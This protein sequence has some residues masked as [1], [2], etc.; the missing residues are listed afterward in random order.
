MKKILFLLCCSLFFSIRTFAGNITSNGTGGGNWN[1]T[2]TWV[3][4]VV[5]VAGDNA[6]I[7]VGDVITITTNT[8]VTNITFTGGNGSATLQLNA[9]V[10]LTASGAVTINPP[11]GGNNTNLLSIGDGVLSC[12]SLTTSN[13]G[14]NTRICQ[15]SINTGTLTCTG[16][17]TLGN[18]T[19]R[20]TLTFTS[21]GLLQLGS[22]TNAL[23]NAQFTPSTGTVEYNMAGAQ[24]VLALSYSSL[25]CSGSGIKSLA[26]ATT[27]TGNLTITGTAQL[28]V[29]SGSNFALNVAGNWNVTSTNA[30]PFNAE[31]G[32]VTLNGAALQNVTTVLAGGEVFYNLTV[33]NTSGLNP[34]IQIN[35][36][37]TILGS[38]TLNFIQTTTLTITGNLTMNSTSTIGG[39][40]TGVLNVNGTFSDVAGGSETIGRVTMNV[41][42]ASSLGGTL[43][44]SSATGT[45]NMN[46]GLT[47]ANSSNITYGAAATLNIGTSLTCN[48]TNS[49]TYSTAGTFS[50]AAVTI[51][52][53]TTFDGAATGITNFASTLGVAAAANLNLGRTTAT[54]TG[55][56]T[57]TGSLTITNVTGA[58]NLT[59]GAIIANGGNI[60]FSV[61]AT[62]TIGTSLTC[63][64]TNSITYNAA[65][66][67]SSTAATVNGTTIIDGTTTG[68]T[69]FTSTVNVPSGGILTIGNT[70]LTISN[71]L[72]VGGTTAF[73]NASG[74]KTFNNI[75]INAGGTWNA[76]AV[77]QTYYISAGNLTNN[78]TFNAGL[79]SATVYS[80]SGASQIN[81]T[82]TI[83]TVA[84]TA[85]TTTNYATLTISNQLSGA[86]SFTQ[87][88]TGY[89][90]LS[91]NTANFTVTTFVA[92]AASNTV[93]YTMA[94]AQTIKKVTYYNLTISTS[95]TKTLAGA[96]V[97][98]NNV[99]ITGTAQLDVSAS[100][101][102]LSVG[103]NWNLTSTNA[104]PFN[105][106]A[107]TVTFNGTSGTQ[108]LSTTVSQE[109]FYNL[110]I[111]NISGSATGVSLDKNMTVNNI[112][113]LTSG[114]LNIGT[115]SLTC[116]G[117]TAVNAGG[118]SG[119]GIIICTGAQVIFGTTLG[120][121]TIVPTVSI[122]TSSITMQRG[123][124]SNP[125]SVYKISSSSV[126]DS[127]RGGNTFNGTFTLNN[128]AVGDTL[129]P[130][131]DVYLGANSGDPTDIFNANSYFYVTGSS[132][133]RC[134][135]SGTIVFNAPAHFYSQ[136]FASATKTSYDRIQPARYSPAI[137]TFNDSSIFFCNSI[138]T[139]IYIAYDPG[140]TA[141]F[142]KPVVAT[143]SGTS[144]ANFYFGGAGVVNLNDDVYFNNTGSG[145]IN[146]INQTGGVA[147]LA[148]TKRL[149]VGSKGFSSGTLTMWNL[150]Q[151]G[152]TA[153]S[154]T[155]TGSA[156]MNVGGAGTPCTFNASVAFTSPNINLTENTFNGT[157]NI[158]TMSGSTN[159]N[160]Y[161]GNIYA[162]GST[163]TFIN[164]S[165]GYW[166]LANTRGDTCYGDAI[167]KK[168]STG[169]LS[170][171]YNNTNYFYGNISI[172]AGSDSI[173][174][175]AGTGIV[176][177]MGTSSSAFTN[178][179]NKGVSMKR[180]VLNKTG[181]AGFTLNNNLGVPS[182][183]SLTLTSGLL[184]TSSTGYLF[185]MN[186]N[187]T[188]PAL[189]DALTSYI[190]GPMRYD[191]ASNNTTQT[192]NF[193]IG[194]AG[195][196]RPVVLTVR[197]NAAT[198]YSYMGEVFNA[199]PWVAMNSG[200]PYIAT[201]MPST[202]DTISG[203]HY[204]TFN[205]TVTSSGASASATNLSYSAGAYPLIQLYFGPNDQVYQGSNLTIVK[206]TSATP[207][208]WIDIGGSCA[209][210]NF[211]S[212]QSGNVTST[213]SPTAFNSFSSFTLGSRNT[214]W[215]PLPI[216]LLDFTA[217]PNGEKVDIKWE[218][219][220]EEN[221]SYFTVEKSKDGQ[222]F[223]KLIDV[224]GAGN[225]HTVLN[226]FET[227]YQ[228]YKGTSYYRLKQ[229]DK[230]GNYKYFNVVS[231]NFDGQ[232]NIIICP[233]P[234]ISGNNTSVKVTGYQN[235]EVLMILTDMQGR[236]FL[237]KVLLSGDYEH[238]FIIDETGTLPPGTYIVTATSNN[239][240]YNYKLIVR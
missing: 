31:A 23:L 21:G 187:V 198:S 237:T 126:T 74:N 38:T 217:A 9:G 165:T 44:L 113:T 179:G 116:L 215:N 30:L 53:T 207:A 26:A 214:G 49:V 141:I 29:V 71:T 3:G 227:D 14:T 13:S 150:T 97:V 96:T 58:K 12:A 47:M 135:Q 161:G 206:N 173:D 64:G 170:A 123:T 28:D 174:F 209:L 65:G 83:P 164:S 56:S 168:A 10:V 119:T 176:T 54:A 72:T 98:S 43:T 115:Y 144:Q 51:N 112:F 197:H 146:I 121:P 87:G 201:N 91:L 231:V 220:S 234:I 5:P 125:V 50:T 93:D 24:P 222:S 181:G 158:F 42:G 132:R 183:G 211:S 122:T 221:N 6:I 186:Q 169:E 86:G 188:A 22:N 39:T 108:A 136:G 210:G 68:T 235:E 79:T 156:I 48:G 82:L 177:L 184:N 171:A 185:L 33:S 172:A 78:G 101:Y 15:I 193:P 61:A 157:T 189:T 232:Q 129:D 228:P 223:T 238:P 230:N 120:G 239:K 1:A 4:G 84:V 102:A 152:T 117:N 196:C 154:L 35:Q 143:H 130:A 20:N 70:A 99:N 55:V 69:N 94:G 236:E 145:T 233:N 180:I 37:Q 203:V 205:R 63:N 103:G 81:G 75:T 131:G 52:G 216:Q 32:T 149:L 76:S 155:F 138:T 2:T 199:N 224:P 45:K 195:D 148:N 111:N 25:K 7:A 182:G 175:G 134:P 202:V 88:N 90:Y 107:G 19:T 57:I 200:S 89:L 147:T 142:N 166:R 194:K 85:N 8:A 229:T 137:V 104:L 17:F 95:G 162:S 240:I 160:C 159:Q 73:T 16:N 106:E 100:N 105:A 40:V 204:W 124:Y 67:L 151:V 59:G 212:G 153:Q 46:G 178:N 225:S 208:A 118:I 191:V 41:T 219:A 140:T 218:T 11:T 190:N 133:I 34:G 213:S 163:N 66:I 18:N 27:L 36:N 226:Y 139:D 128:G 167:F 77:D 92:S 62:L 109:S 60:T 80:F 110:T 127:W 114:T 192:L